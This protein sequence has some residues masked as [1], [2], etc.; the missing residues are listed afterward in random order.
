[1]RDLYQR[2]LRPTASE[3]EIEWASYGATVAV[4]LTVAVMA[5]NPPQY[6]QLIVVFASSGMASAFLA[7]ALLGAFW[8]RATHEGAIA[9]MA[10]G[11]STTLGLYLYG[12]ILGRNGYDPG[13][14]AGG[15]AFVPYYFLGLD[16]CIWGLST[17]LAVAVIVSLLSPRPDPAR[18]ALLFD[19]QPPDAPAPATLDLHRES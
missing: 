7:P 8:R 15:N 4:G 19:V 17:S 13:I 16:P 3:K 18:I 9:S 12:L 14:G 1:V 5:I 11:A 10:T 6:L 2:F